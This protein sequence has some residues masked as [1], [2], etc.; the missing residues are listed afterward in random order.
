M[1]YNI[2]SIRRYSNAGKKDLCLSAIS[3]YAD[4]RT[5]NKGAKQDLG[6]L[7]DCVHFMYDEDGEGVTEFWLEDLKDWTDAEIREY[8]KEQ[9]VHNYTPYDC[10][11]KLCTMYISFHRNPSG[12][13]SFVHCKTLDV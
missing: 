5:Y 2:A 6:G 9:E 4:K 10:S 3:R 11:G 1:K 7:R 8:M 13:V 12:L